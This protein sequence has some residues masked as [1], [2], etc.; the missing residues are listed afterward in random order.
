MSTMTSRPEMTMLSALHTSLLTAMACAVAVP[1]GAQSK[2]CPPVD[3]KKL[4]A[5]EMRRLPSTSPRNPAALRQ[6]LRDRCWPNAIDLALNSYQ[7]DLPAWVVYID[8]NGVVTQGVTSKG[9]DTRILKEQ[10]YIWA[11]VVS[12]IR[13][14]PPASRGTAATESA[15][16]DTALLEA[17]EAI[18]KARKAAAAAPD[19]KADDKV[20]SAQADADLAEHK[21]TM[22]SS[23]ANAIEL[24]SADLRF[25]RR[26]VI[27]QQDPMLAVLIKGI[28]KVVGFEAA[29]TT[30]KLDD[31]VAVMDLRQMSADPKEPIWIGLARFS[32]VQN[33]E[34]ELSLRLVI[35]KQLVPLN[36]DVDSP[37]QLER[38]YTNVA[39]AKRRTFEIGVLG[40]LAY[41]PPLQTI[42]ANLEV[43]A[44]SARY[45]LGG[46]A[47][48]FWNPMWWPR[49]V[50]GKRQWQ[51]PSIG[52]FVG[53]N[54]LNATFGDQ[55]IAGISIGH[56]LSDA[57]LAVGAAWL[58]S[59]QISGGKVVNHRARR[60][61][62][63]I[64]I[65][66]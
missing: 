43:T 58:P 13:P 34:T 21:A 54:V 31:S 17:K 23:G 32:L 18:A 49:P 53:T 51:R 37:P 41:G 2:K 33:T 65:R 11:L 44:T 59:Q 15:N 26:T 9:Y 19:A 66:L 29:S 48:L 52:P 16:A 20:K 45:A 25:A 27:Y 28:G 14:A 64:D 61:L 30:P 62:V 46:Y 39:N 8:A 10:Q 38:I 55:L 60:A 24:D 7:R 1:L 42:N 4:P 6:A 5:F 40:G 50:V 22:A 63:G 3:D 35:P 36:S 57:G 12:D 56:L 47:T